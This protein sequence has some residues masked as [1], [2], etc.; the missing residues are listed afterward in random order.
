[1]SIA[2][3]KKKTKA[4]C[5]TLSKGQNG[6]SLN[7]TT[8]TN[9]SSWVGGNVISRRKYYTPMKGTAYRGN[10]SGCCTKSVIEACNPYTNSKTIRKS[11]PGTKGMLSN[12][13]RECV[14][15]SYPNWIVKHNNKH[16]DYDVYLQVITATYGS[17]IESQNDAGIK[18]CVNT[19]GIYPSTLTNSYVKDV[20]ISD[21]D[22]YIKTNY[23]KNNCITK[24][25]VGNPYVSINSFGIVLSGHTVFVVNGIYQ[26]VFSAGDITSINNVS[27]DSNATSYDL[28]MPNKKSFTIDGA[29]GSQTYTI[30]N[31]G[32]YIL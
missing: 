14:Y 28:K 16:L 12:K 9:S 25:P 20:D 6:F 11:T 7:G 18:T 8:N 30:I 29:S 2:T 23:L 13:L 3:L 4:K 27:I 26:F 17:C 1:M 31:T 21:Q 5:C 24:I 32:Q 22:I 10:G 15:G 19:C